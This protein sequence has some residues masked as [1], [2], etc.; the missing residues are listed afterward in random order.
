MRAQTSLIMVEFFFRNSKPF[1]YIG[2]PVAVLCLALYECDQDLGHPPPYHH[3]GNHQQHQEE[4][5]KITEP[6]SE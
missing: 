4:D 1:S 3:V 5:K 2:L 6:K